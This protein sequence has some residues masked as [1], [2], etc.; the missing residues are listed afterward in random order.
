M[1]NVNSLLGEPI[2]NNIN[3]FGTPCKKCGLEFLIPLILSWNGHRELRSIAG[4]HI[5]WFIYISTKS[6]V[7]YL[8]NIAFV[9]VLSY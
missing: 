8:L 5:F 3:I 9:T 2:F 4:E 1:V 6:K 7:V